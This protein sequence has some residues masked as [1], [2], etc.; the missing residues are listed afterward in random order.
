MNDVPFDFGF[1]ERFRIP[2]KRYRR[3]ERITVQ[4]EIGERMYVV[5]EG[6]VDIVTDGKLLESVG[7]H[8]IFGEIAL[9]DDAPRSADALAAAD[10]EVAIVD[11]NAF[12]ELVGSNPR[13]SLY[14][15]QQ[16]AHRIR[17]MNERL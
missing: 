8:G 3:G 17:R 16:M 7:L 4:G 11:R 12:L 14:V 2:L 13:F 5:L 15:M 1:F 10:T 6:K 9:I